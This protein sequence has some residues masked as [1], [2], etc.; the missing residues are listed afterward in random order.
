MRTFLLTTQCL[1]WGKQINKNRP[2]HVSLSEYEH[3]KLLTVLKSLRFN[4]CSQRL[5]AV[6]L[7]ICGKFSYSLRMNERLARRS[8]SLTWI[9]QAYLVSTWL[10]RA[11]SRE[12]QMRL[13]LLPPQHNN[14]FYKGKALFFLTVQIEHLEKNPFP[15][16][17]NITP[18]KPWLTSRTETKWIAIPAMKVGTKQAFQVWCR[19]RVPCRHT[20]RPHGH[21]PSTTPCF[22]GSCPTPSLWDQGSLWPFSIVQRS[23]QQ[24]GGDTCSSF[25]LSLFTTDSSTS[26]MTYSLPWHSVT[27]ELFSVKGRCPTAQIVPI[28]WHGK[29]NH[30]SKFK[31]P[32]NY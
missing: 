3:I 9:Y 31:H 12:R 25:C 30:N 26:C 14:V 4:L 6:V 17:R 5:N 2:Q 22:S 19:A 7:S 1:G 24:C 29:P 20:T 27:A 13:L 21:L 23:P 18:H 8:Y 10:T 28:C 32:T 15:L 11:A 16:Q